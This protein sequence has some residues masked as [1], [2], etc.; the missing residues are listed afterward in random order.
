MIA[1]SPR[2]MRLLTSFFLQLLLV[3]SISP[4]SFSSPAPLPGSS[5]CLTNTTNPSRLP[6]SVIP[7]HY[8]LRFDLP[9]PDDVASTEFSG[10][11]RINVEVLQVTTC[12]V[13]HAAPSIRF[14]NSYFSDRESSMIISSSIEYDLLNEMA[15]IT[16][17]SLLPAAQGILTINFTAS[18]RTDGAGLFRC[19]NV[20]EPLSNPVD[21]DVLSYSASRHH[22]R[23]GEHMWW[24]GRHSHSGRKRT[25]HARR[26]AIPTLAGPS[27]FIS[28]TP[29]PQSPHSHHSHATSAPK[30]PQMFATQLEQSDARSV[31]P[32]FDEPALKAT[33]TV[34][35]HVTSTAD[36]YTVLFNT[37]PVSSSYDQ[38]VLSVSFATTLMPIS[39]YLL[40]IAVGHFDLINSTTTSGIPV[41]IFTPP[42]LSSWGAFGL[43]ATIQSIEYFERILAFNYSRMNTKM[44]SVSVSGIVDDGMENQGLITYSPGFLL[45]NP[46]TCDTGDYIMIML[47]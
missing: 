26:P 8:S 43:N 4:V 16:F 9:A 47:V 27:P 39:T 18:L 41:R 42:K 14:L 1:L 10:W 36:L 28:P 31:F 3:S 21:S 11:A 6:S 40:A 37:D 25:K 34:N 15:T 17:P 32:C 19:D 23:R 22:G 29:S 24:G 20:Y 12:I 33:F 2:T 35:I 38:G 44:D 13:I 45:C 5:T 7:S 46:N 30:H